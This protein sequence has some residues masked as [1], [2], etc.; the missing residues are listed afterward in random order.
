MGLDEC[1]GCAWGLGVQ[2][3]GLCLCGLVGC[4]CVWKG[5]EDYVCG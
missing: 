3:V 2:E 5:V 1:V 4:G